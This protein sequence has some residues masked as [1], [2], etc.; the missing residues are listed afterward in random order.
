MLACEYLMTFNTLDFQGECATILRNIS[1]PFQ[2]LIPEEFTMNLYVAC[3]KAWFQQV[4]VPEHCFMEAT[5][6]FS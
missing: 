6:S 2:S 5:K 1:N 3:F 4:G